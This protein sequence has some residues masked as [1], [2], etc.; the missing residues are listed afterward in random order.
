MAFKFKTT[1]FNLEKLI[2]IKCGQH[3]LVY[4]EIEGSTIKKFGLKEPIN[5]LDNS[6]S[7][8]KRRKKSKKV[9]ENRF[10]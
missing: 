6:L 7:N 9:I 10:L 5:K 3:F 8:L 4:L 1:G 2:Y